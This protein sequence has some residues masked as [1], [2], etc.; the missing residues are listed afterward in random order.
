[1][2]EY[3]HESGLTYSE[4]ELQGYAS[5]ANMSIEDFISAKGLTLKDDTVEDDTVE[6]KEFYEKFSFLS[7]GSEGDEGEVVESGAE[8]VETEEIEEP[9]ML[10]DMQLPTEQVGAYTQPKILKPIEEANIEKD[11][12]DEESDEELKQEHLNQFGDRTPNEILAD[13]LDVGVYAEKVN[14]GRETYGMPGTELGAEQFGGDVFDPESINA[15][16]FGQDPIKINRS[17]RLDGGRNEFLQRRSNT[18]RENFMQSSEIAGDVNLLDNKIIEEGDNYISYEDEDIVKLR[19]DGEIDKAN[20]LAKQR[21]YHPLIND[22]TGDLT[23][24]I[25]QDVQDKAQNLAETKDIDVLLEERRRKYFELIASGKLAHE[26][27]DN[28]NPHIRTFGDVGDIKGGFHKLKDLFGAEKTLDN[29][30]DLLEQVYQTG[31]LPAGLNKLPSKTPLSR[32][33]NKALKDFVTLNRAIEINADLSKLDQENYFKEIVAPTNDKIVASMSNMLTDLG[34]EESPDAVK[35]SVASGFSQKHGLNVFGEKANVRKTLEG[36]RDVVTHLI[37]LAASVY[38]TKK[39]PVGIVSRASK[40]TGKTYM[41]TR[42]LG[43]ALTSRTNAIGKF[44]KIQGPQSRVYNGV[45]DLVTAGINETLVLAAADVPLTKVFGQEPF[46]YNPKTGDLNLAFPFFLGVGNKA[47][48]NILKKLNTT[49]NMFTPMLA[50]IHRSKIAAAAWEGHVGATVGTATMFFAE[51]ITG[52]SLNNWKKFGY[53]SKDEMKNEAGGHSL[54]ETYI[55]M[56]MFQGVSPTFQRNALSKLGRGMHHDVIRML[57]KGMTPRQKAAQKSFGIE[58]NANGNF[59]LGEVNQIEGQRLSE[60]SKIK[61]VEKRQLEREKI[62]HQGNQLRLHNNIKLAKKIAKDKKKYTQY[63]TNIFSVQQNLNISDK[64]TAKQMKQFA[65]LSEIELKWLKL[66]SGIAEGSELDRA[67]NNKHEVYNNLL[68]ATK[69]IRIFGRLT[70]EQEE[71]H[72]E[73]VLEGATIAGEINYLKKQIELK[74]ELKAVH[75]ARIKELTERS[76]KIGVDVLKNEKALNKII[77]EKFD[78]EVAFAKVV[79]GK[80][81]MGFNVLGEEAYIKVAKK[82]GVDVVGYR[83]LNNEF[84]R[85]I[86]KRINNLKKQI[87]LDPK[88]KAI[89]EAEIKRLNSKIQKERIVS[90]GR[91]VKR[92]NKYQIYINKDA[93]LKVR[94]LGT[95][96]HELT[97]AI[98]RKALKDPETGKISEQ[99]EKIINQF[100][101]QLNPQERAAVEKRIQKNYMYYKKANGEFVKVDGK[102]VKKPKEEYYEEY[103]TAFGDVLK[104]KEVKESLDLANRVKDVIYPIMQAVGFKNLR[105]VSIDQGKGLFNMIKALQRSSETQR[106]PTE[107]LEF[108]KKGKELTVSD[109]YESRTITEG[110]K[111]ASAEI[112]RIYKT[113]GKGG[114]NTIINS[115]KGRDAKGKREYDERGNPKK[116]FIKKW[117]EKHKGTAGYEINKDII[118]DRMA[119]HEV[120]GVLGAIMSYTPTRNPS[121]ASHIFGRLNVKH[122]DIANE[123]LGKGEARVFKE[124]IDILEAREL[125]SKEMSADR[126]YDLKLAEKERI[127]NEVNL[128][129]SL[130][131]GKEKGINQKLIDKVEKAVIQSFGT[132]LPLPTS[133]KIRQVLEDNYAT[134]LEKPIKDLMGKGPNYEVF[135]RDNYEAIMKHV[136]KRHFIQMERE[137]PRNKRVFTEV[138]IENMNP[139]QTKK[140]INEGRVPTTT[141]LTAG[142]TLYKFKMPTPAQFVRF[143]IPPSEIISKKTGKLVKSGLKGTRKD[144]LAQIMGST[145]GKDMTMEVVNRPEFVAKI[146]DIALLQLNPKI[147]TVDKPSVEVVNARKEVFDNYVNLLAEKIGRDPNQKFSVTEFKDQIKELEELIRTKPIG[148]VFNLKT[149]K[150]I[151]SR[152]DGSKYNEEAYNTALDAYENKKLEADV[153]AEGGKTRGTGYE[154]SVDRT[155]KKELKPIKGVEVIS[156]ITER[157][158]E[159]KPQDV[160]EGGKVQAP[161][162]IIEW[163]NQTIQAWELK[164]KEAR[165]PKNSAGFVN[166]SQAVRDI[167]AGKELKLTDRKNPRENTK[168]EAIFVES[169]KRAIMKG[170]PGVEAVLRERKILKPNEDFTSKTKIP[171]DLHLYELN[172]KAKAKMSDYS[173]T[174]DG[175][176]AAADYNRKGVFEINMAT[177]GAFYLGSPTN[178]I[179]KQAGATLFE[180]NFPL[181]TRVYASSYKA[182]SGPYATNKKGEIIRDKKGKPVYPTAGYTYKIIG[183]GIIKPEYITSKSKLN[184]DKPGAWQKMANTPAAKALKAA[185]SAEVKLQKANNKQQKKAIGGGMESRTTKESLKNAKIID[186]AFE[187]GRDRKKKPQGMSTFDFDETL[188]VKGKNFITAIEPNT[189]RKVKISSANWPIEGPKFAE[190]G[191]TFDFKDFVNVR[192]GTEGPLLQKMRNQIKK[193][194]VDNVFVLTAR[195]AESNTAIYGWL[196]SQGITIPMKNITG[197]GNSTGEAKAM[198]MLKKFSEGYNDMYFVDDALPN[199]KAVKHILNQL[200]IKSKVQQVYSKTQLGG[201]INNM[202]QRVFKI[203]A[204][205]VFSK[206]E[207]KIRGKDAKRRKFFM[208]D[209]ASDLELLLEPLYG[210]GKE[211][212]KNKQW[213]QDNLYR[214]FERGINNLNNAKQRATNEYYSLRKQNKDVIKQLDKPVGETSFSH[215]MAMRVYLWNKAGFK[216]PD[217]AKSTEK[218]LVDHINNNPKLKAYAEN[219][220]KITKVEKGIKEP[221]ENWWAETMASNISEM[222]AGASRKSFLKDFIQRKNEIFTEQNLNKMESKLGSN[223]R[224]IIEDMFSRME[225]GRSRSEKVTEGT[226]RLLNYLNGSVGAI[227]NF[228]TRSGVLQLISSVNFI[229]YAENNPLAAARAFANQPQYWRDFMFIMNSNMLKQRRAGLKINVN[230]AELAASVKKAKNPASRALAYILKQGYLPTKIADSFAIASGGATYYRNRIKKYQKEGLSTKEA[231]KKA[232]IDFQKVAERTQQSSRADLLSREQTTIAGKVILPFANTPLQ[233]NRIMI[234]DILDISKGRYEG[235][236]GE[237]SLTA[238]LSRIAYY[239]AVQNVIFAGLQSAL[240]AVM[241]GSDDEPLIAQKKAR[242]VNTVADSFLRGMGIKGAVV[243][244]FK[245]AILKFFQENKKGYQADYSEVAEQL[246]NISPPI[247]SKF[248]KL[249]AAGNTYKYNKKEIA[250]GGLTLNGPALEATTQ[251]VE[252]ITNVPVNRVY[253]K[254]ENIINATNSDYENWQRIMM[255]GG[256]TAWDVGIDKKETKTKSKKK[257]KQIKEQVILN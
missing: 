255:F 6:D 254:T 245:N 183:E 228:N 151:V 8:E 222:G 209:S 103:I 239:G 95:P 156:E 98:L 146:R 2:A 114:Y 206:A 130:M 169:V 164:Y 75:E 211:G 159:L 52:P 77:K 150:P 165:L 61:D 105:S 44:F 201:D 179:S 168:E 51:K 3:T 25:P 234:K 227:M 116:D 79:A 200:D 149:R 42:T 62:K 14:T 94:Q 144:R 16:L 190:Q 126:L 237:N 160:F 27:L 9:S 177:K 29:S 4:D 170:V 113:E 111:E 166:Y 22:E 229:N 195:P 37:P 33:Y 129:K 71:K 238:K 60:T 11:K 109:V 83:K 220:S 240:F 104:N 85:K 193:Y 88:N 32:Q 76:K 241:F 118:Y 204:N 15:A 252:A 128:R 187:L 213:F 13:E 46:V 67:F 18:E 110:Q 50:Q 64:P 68:E 119:N 219:F 202:M 17:N 112:D 72:L 217:L 180:G 161:D 247:G 253:K 34:Y 189:G 205:K 115:F 181:A 208:P 108:A 87:R 244:G 39:L 174:V 199:V 127:K 225:T 47:A 173:Q 157:K 251:M 176:W 43:S 125:V 20:E 120:Y 80:M 132:K 93:A 45:V 218:K 40:L 54:V 117:A 194:G 1:M 55:A 41:T 12:F 53:D 188:I 153:I 84:N 192:G 28:P 221:T 155:A 210:K 74:P 56:W 142:N 38:L 122:I 162:A 231:E 36:A 148:E 81:G 100:L 147:E 207:G 49:K 191:Y 139:T 91:F 66:K 256:W 30:I 21:G 5:E 124:S 172:H 230:E 154:K 123:V 226:T 131:F 224:E 99:G 152:K 133:K 212:M 107:I 250:E 106:I 78:A 26:N 73:L 257:K 101:E 178:N 86:E 90:E 35:R 23:G 158:I 248:S 243:A 232:F 136:D 182:T 223:W 138:E 92:G 31:N 203:D 249:D 24:W 186:K 163:Y 70:P 235:Y 242:T 102:K 140:A 96:L 57:N 7:E 246:L 137:L 167:K 82:Q 58:K 135:L 141:S 65:N 214:Q 59:N 143:F 19:R 233:Y 185:A 69:G 197:L 215:D 171:L 48:G 145:M 121:L 198:W 97:H 236:F 134:E 216:I 63:L 10:K 89:Y 175:K 196:K 184:I